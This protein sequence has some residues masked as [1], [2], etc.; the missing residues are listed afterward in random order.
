MTIGTIYLLLDYVRRLDTPLEQVRTQMA[1]LQRASAS[2][3]RVQEL[4]RAR[5]SVVER[6][7]AELPPGT[8]PGGKLSVSFENVSFRY[9]DDLAGRGTET[10]LDGVSFT[11]APG[12]ALGL[13]GRTGSGKT[14]LTRLLFRLYDPTRGAIKLGGVDLRDAR[15]GDLR[16]RVGLVTQDVQLFQASVRDNV[17]FFD[18]NVPD[19]QILALLDELGLQDWLRSHPKGLDSQL[20]S[21]GQGLSAGQAQL[22]ALARV[23]LQDP[24][25]VVLDEASS[26]LDPVTEQLLERAISRLLQ[27]RTA[28]IIAHRLN[29]VQR[30]D[31]ILILENGRVREHG[32]RQALASDP[33]SRFYGLLQTGLLEEALA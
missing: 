3:A 15:L 9:D 20:A 29:T 32:Q 22:L 13:L 30:S 12:Q 17:T 7:R 24:G 16:A 21:G 28:I 18:K 1:D 4:F 10:V 25:L 19:A 2:I 23:F 27:G 8:M 33:A 6:P 31:E 14:T 5:P 11:L 26:R